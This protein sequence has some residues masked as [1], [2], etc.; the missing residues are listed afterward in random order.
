MLTNIIFYDYITTF[1]IIVHINFHL[2]NNFKTN[3]QHNFNLLNDKKTFWLNN[4]LLIFND[5]YKL[6]I[7]VIKK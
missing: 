5:S 4:E 1:N 6:K 3:L 2:L 7:A